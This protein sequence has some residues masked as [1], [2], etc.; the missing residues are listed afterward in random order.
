[1]AI[2][3]VRL[4]CHTIVLIFV[5]AN[6]AI[7]NGVYGTF[8]VVFQTVVGEIPQLYF[9]HTNSFVDVHDMYVHKLFE[10]GSI[11]FCLDFET[12][13]TFFSHFIR[14]NTNNS[15]NYSIFNK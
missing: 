3:L 13:L 1:V 9:S 2:T 6:S 12:V 4:L 5:T 15:D 14:P 10:M 8:L 11:I 7:R